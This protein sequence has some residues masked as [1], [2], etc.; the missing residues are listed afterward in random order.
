MSPY[1]NEKLSLFLTEVSLETSEENQLSY[2]QNGYFFK[3]LWWSHEPHNKGICRW[4]NEIISECFTINNHGF[5]FVSFST[6]QTLVNKI[7]FFSQFQ[8]HRRSPHIWYHLLPTLL[9][10]LGTNPS[11]HLV[12]GQCFG[13][14]ETYEKTSG[15]T[16]MCEASECNVRG[17]VTQEDTS[18]TRDCIAI[19]K[20]SSAC[21]TFTVGKK[22]LKF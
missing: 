7:P 3:I 5:S 4:K 9:L 18:V 17:L 12:N 20:Q 8:R 21:T 22:N 6:D 16:V 13:G 19:C 14:V 11:I 2:F 1:F 15:T 10:W